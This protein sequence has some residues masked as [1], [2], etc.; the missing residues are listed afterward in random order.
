MSSNPPQQEERSGSTD[1][2]LLKQ[3]GLAGVYVSER[4]AAMVRFAISCSLLVGVAVAAFHVGTSIE[5]AMIGASLGAAIMMVH[6]GEVED[7]TA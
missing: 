7:P 5:L 2:E 6:K 3:S 1:H 4:E